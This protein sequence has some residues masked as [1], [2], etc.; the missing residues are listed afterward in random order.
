MLERIKKSYHNGIKQARLLASFF[1]ERTKVET[2]MARQFYET[3]KLE[4]KLDG[5][6]TDIGKRV[7]ELE[8]RGE[9]E[10]LKDGI[11]LQMVGEVKRVKKQIEDY[12]ASIQTENKS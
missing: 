3:T 7:A 12:K 10:V 6:Y 1:A 8:D 5:F 11:I 2:S 9:K 4:T